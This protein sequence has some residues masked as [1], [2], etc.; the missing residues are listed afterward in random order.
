MYAGALFLPPIPLSFTS[1]ARSKLLPGAIVAVAYL[2][3]RP[4]FCRAGIFHFS[5]LKRLLPAAVAFYVFGHAVYFA[6]DG[7]YLVALNEMQWL[8]Y[9]T[10]PL[11]MAWDVGPPGATYLIKALLACL[12]IE[13]ILAV[14]SSFT[15]PMYDYVVLWY[16][17]R[18]GTSVYRAVGTMDSTNSLG[19]LMAFGALTCL[20]APSAV[21]PVRRS[22]MVI[23]LLA[24]VIFSQS[25]SAFFS[26]FI[27]F[28]LVSLVSTKWHLMSTR[29]LWAMVGSQ[30]LALMLVGAVFY[31]YGDAVADNMNQDYVDRTALSERAIDKIAEFDWAQTIFG[32]GFHGVDYVNPATG[33]WITAHNSYIN[34]FA[35]LGM[36]GC[37]LVVSLLA[38][39]VLTILKNRQWHLLA[40]V[41][42]LLMHFVTEAFLYAPL[43]VMTIGTLYGVTCVY[44]RGRGWT[45]RRRSVLVEEGV[46]EGTRA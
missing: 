39:L 15:G 38:V 8:V 30:V 18:F 14:I 11:L 36:C 33:A 35:D 19:G 37:S 23:G 5:T 28:A 3:W 43:F 9:L 10:A 21:L 13:S 16:G 31:L 40:G 27:G 20:F 32:V 17:P 6:L 41:L 12:G 25:K 26:V 29:E 46:F 45:P 7:N 44:S 42:G 24:G 2:I 4:I 22:L 1:T 34:L